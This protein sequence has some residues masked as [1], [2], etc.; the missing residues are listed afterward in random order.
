MIIVTKV[1]CANMELV[2]TYHVVIL[3]NVIIL[4][5]MILLLNLAFQV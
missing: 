2:K 1:E 4:S 3:V 5:L